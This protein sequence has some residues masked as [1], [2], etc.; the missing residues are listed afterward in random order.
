[1][2]AIIVFFLLALALASRCLASC[3]ILNVIPGIILCPEVCETSVL[4]YDCVG[5]CSVD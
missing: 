1:M 4:E 5:A 3:H 2:I